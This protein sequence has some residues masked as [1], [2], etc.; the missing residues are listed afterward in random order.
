MGP[1]TNVRARGAYAAVAALGL[2]NAV[3][4]S[5]AGAQADSALSATPVVAQRN[6]ADLLRYGQRVLVVGRLANGQAGAPLALEYLPSGT[7][8]WSVL[9]TRA[10]STGGAFRLSAPLTSSGVVRVALDA[11]V[12]TRALPQAPQASALSAEL[13]V[14]VSAALSARR[15]DLNVLGGHPVIVS[16]TLRPAKAGRVVVLQLRTGNRWTTV[17][18]AKT[19]ARGRYRLRFMPHRTGSQVARVRFAGDAQNAS[20][21]D[22]L[23]LLNVYR[24]AAASWY[25]GGGSL[26]CGGT[27][28]AGTMGVANLT[29]PCGTIVTLHYNGR[30]VRVPVIDRGPYVAGREFDL[31]AATK[32][33]LGFGDLG[34]LWTT[35]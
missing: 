32:A 23:G 6:G 18:R 21:G 12:V 17:A 3:M 2:T 14:Q 30:T 25:G 24:L 28:S 33:A 11:A 20:V 10:S 7:T 1:Q 13:P 34:T 19:G 15:A 9:A 8:T 31:T 16:G 22:R 5:P 26:A 4:D 27:L 29:L 35:R